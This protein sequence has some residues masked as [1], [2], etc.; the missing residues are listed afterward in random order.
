[1]PRKHKANVLDLN[2][3]AAHVRQSDLHGWLGEPQFASGWAFLNRSCYA[4]FGERG[5]EDRVPRGTRIASI[6]A[7]L[8][9]VIASPKVCTA[10]PSERAYSLAGSSQRCRGRPPC[11]RKHVHKDGLRLGT[12]NL[13]RFRDHLTNLFRRF[14]MSVGKAGG[15]A[16]PP[17]PEHAD[18]G[19]ILARHLACGGCRRSCR[20]RLPMRRIPFASTS[21]WCPGLRHSTET[22]THPGRVHR[23]ARHSR[24]A[25][26]RIPKADGVLADIA[27]RSR[28]L[29]GGGIR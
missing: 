10:T 26:L 14:E 2:I 18:Q 4:D 23:A 29:R 6:S 28:A 17:V 12:R 16:A 15:G 27:P 3:L 19:Q 20:R 11:A 7:Q 9:P 1:M 24:R 8:Q 5:S 13:H 22:G 21:G 25:G